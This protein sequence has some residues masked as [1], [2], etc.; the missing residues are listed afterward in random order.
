MY[1]I[2]F[3]VQSIKVGYFVEQVSMLQPIGSS[4]ATEIERGKN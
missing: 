4:W 2:L 1:L 3:N